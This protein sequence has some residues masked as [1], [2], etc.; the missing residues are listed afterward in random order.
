M[1]VRL[2]AADSM[3]VSQYHITAPVCRI[4]WPLAFHFFSTNVHFF[5][6]RGGSIVLE[7][8]HGSLRAP[9]TRDWWFNINKH[10][11]LRCQILPRTCS[12]AHGRNGHRR[13]KPLSLFAG[14]M[15]SLSALHSGVVDTNLTCGK[16]NQGWHKLQQTCQCMY[17]N[18]MA[19]AVTY[20]ISQKICTDFEVEGNRT[21]VNPLRSHVS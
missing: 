6:R 3:T 2:A 17:R 16:K 13:Q 8:L 15:T 20:I 4:E 12:E 14:V 1:Q 11:E 19:L 21:P 9:R 5:S 7:C 18:Q 10:S